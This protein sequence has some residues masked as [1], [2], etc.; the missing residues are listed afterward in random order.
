M[1]RGY[2]KLY[3]A[4]L[5]NQFWEERPFSR[6]QAWVDLLLLTNH[7][8]GY[9]RI[10]GNRVA[11]KRGQCGWS[12]KALAERWG[13][14]RGKAQRFLDELQNEHQ[15]EQQKNSVTTLITIVK[16]EQYQEKRTPEQTP[17]RTADGQQTDTNKNGKK[18]TP[19]ESA[20]PNAWDMGVSLG[21]ERSVIGRQIKMAGEEKVAQV[22]GE[23]LLKRPADPT[24]YLIAATQKKKRGFVA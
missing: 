16:Y 5:D 21:V 22:L 17:E 19:T 9:L 7:K 1:E 15:I 11:V 13:W 10:R 3:R 8:P 24:Q 2:I 18:I 6:G 12:V 14:S 23:M 20:A 4:L